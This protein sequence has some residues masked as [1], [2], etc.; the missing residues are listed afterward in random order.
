MLCGWGVARILQSKFYCAIYQKMKTGYMKWSTFYALGLLGWV[1]KKLAMSWIMPSLA[2]LLHIV[3]S[4]TA[5]SYMIWFNM[6]LE[7]S[8]AGQCQTNIY[9]A[10]HFVRHSKNYNCFWC[11]HINCNDNLHTNTHTC[12]TYYN[13]KNYFILLIT[14]KYCRVTITSVWSWNYLKT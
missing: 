13:N 12:Q 7:I 2:L 8:V 5:S 4:M 1:V 11:K 10:W 9:L 6:Y 3:L 14:T